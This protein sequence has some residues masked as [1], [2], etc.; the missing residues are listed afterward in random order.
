MPPFNFEMD[1]F[2]KDLEAEYRAPKEKDDKPA[3]LAMEKATMRFSTNPRGDYVHPWSEGCCGHDRHC[4]PVTVVKASSKH[5]AEK[6]K[7]I[8][9]KAWTALGNPGKAT[10]EFFAAIAEG[11]VEGEAFMPKIPEPMGLGS[12][13][14]DKAG[15]I[16]L[17]TERD[18]EKPW[19]M[20]VKGSHPAHWDDIE[21][22]VCVWNGMIDWRDA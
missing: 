15:H 18:P 8:A 3:K 20:P 17:R 22:V 21:A 1:K 9:D 7:A 13:V 4:I 19:G 12:I 6:I 5:D 10:G 2:F 14:K 16:F 11:L